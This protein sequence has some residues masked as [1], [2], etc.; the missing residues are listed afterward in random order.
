MKEKSTKDLA[1]ELLEGKDI[2][3]VMELQNVLKE[4]LKSGVE[5]L[6]EAELDQELGYEKYSNV[7]VKTN[8]R[9]GTSKK[10]VRSDLG[11][12][13]LDIPRDRNGEFEP[14]LVPK[15]SRD[16]SMIEEKI[17]SMYG[18]GMTTRD[19]SNHINDMYGFE[20]SAE[21]ISHITDKVLPEVE[22][23]QQRPLKK[24]Y[25]FIFMDAIFYKV[26]N[27]NRVVN[28][29]AYIVIGIDSEGQKD[30]LG[31]WIGEY[32]N[33][34]FWLKILTD[35]KN[36]GIKK[37]NIF[38]VDGLPGF[39]QAILA[40]YPNAEVQR[41]IIHQV[42]QSTRY[43]SYKHKFKLMADLRLIYRA[44]NEEEG[45][46]QLEASKE[47]W[48]ALYPSCVKS[49]YQNWDVISPFFKYSKNIRQIMYTTNIIE[50][51]NRQYRKV[52]KAKPIFP[53]DDS[54][55]KALFLATENATKTWRVRVKNWDQ[56][57]YELAILNGE[58]IE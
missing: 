42:R 14:K 20:L 41:C 29:A 19:I 27:N 15:H 9:N 25:Y 40:T 10:T 39:Q 31:I 47:K 5:T 4:I 33:S 13:E 58:D 57:R 36:R 21:S 44:P 55:L 18:K 30:V 28:K 54:L 23:W 16:I 12:V 38:S 6:L 26:K 43:V 11:E 34:K 46:K 45:F 35:L 24:Q 17:I 3:D 48:Q 7:G 22:A 53:T 52:T 37:V 1:K 56:I 8:Y 51:L 50:N 2:K 49:W 32:E